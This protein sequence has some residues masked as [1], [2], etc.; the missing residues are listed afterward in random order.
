MKVGEKYVA[1]VLFALYLLYGL[2]NYFFERTLFFNEILSLG[3]FVVFVA[4]SHVRGLTFRIP[5][6]R[7]YKLVLCLLLLSVFQL[8]V[9]ITLK[10]NWYFYFRNSVIM[11][12]MFTFFTGFYF[13]DYFVQLL[14]H[15]RK[16]ITLFLAF[17][18][19]YP[20]PVVLL[21]RFTASGF[22][23]YLFRKS[24]RTAFIGILVLNVIYAFT[25]SSLTVTIIT[26]VLVTIVV[27]RRYIYLKLLLGVAVAGILIGFLFLAPYLK[28]YKTGPYSLF[29][30]VELVA[31]QH[32]VLGLD[33]NT[34]WRAV[35]WYRLLAERFPENLLGI[36][37]GTPLIEYQPGV[38][39]ADSEYEDEY[40][41]HVFGLHNTYLTLTVRLGILY[42][43]LTLLI[44]DKVF[45]EYY[46]CKNYYRRNNLYLV[47]WS[48]FAITSVGLFNLLLESPTVASLYW[49]T[50]GFVAKVIYHRHR[51]ATGSAP[52]GTPSPASPYPVA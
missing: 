29:G 25:Y 20:M 46:W 6:S 40:N 10:T 7:I 11:Y 28:L 1:Y 27:V 24:N 35:L 30:N 45:K 38:T 32:W 23:P 17:A 37:L 4:K 43:L 36:G 39:T 12:S 33:G 31:G 14:R 5:S 34:T 48:F 47:F 19:S 42:L 51:L 3:G 50:L 13:Y 22:F 26:L 8:L 52:A 18:L 41:A 44:Y 15:L 21:D 16:A 49:T 9:S 2:N